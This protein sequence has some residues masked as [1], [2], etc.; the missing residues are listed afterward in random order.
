MT[1]PGGGFVF[2]KNIPLLAEAAQ[3]AAASDSATS[4]RPRRS[5]LELKNDMAQI[6]L[7]TYS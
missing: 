1:W 5:L 2:P 7:K 6:P 4:K 3:A